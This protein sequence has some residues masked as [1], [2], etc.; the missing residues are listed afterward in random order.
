[1]LLTAAAAGPPELVL[2]ALDFMPIEDGFGEAIVPLGRV[3][4]TRVSRRRDAGERLDALRNL[5]VNRLAR[6]REAAPP[7]V[8][9]VNGVQ[10][11]DPSLLT[12]LD[13]ILHEGP[14]V[15]VHGLIW[16]T[17]PSAVGERV[18]Q[19]CGVRVVG[20]L[21]TATSTA[22]IDSS[23]AAQ[24]RDHQVLLYDEFE[25]RLVLLRPYARAD[26]AWIATTTVS[27][28]SPRSHAE[29]TLT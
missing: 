28:A 19:R 11:A 1:V 24:L 17:T 16:G 12:H 21:D 4:T 9:A 23:R 15:G 2:D 20:P 3:I 22:L 25:S 7:V 29:I 26:A 18:L 8:F 13:Q 5:V 6:H 10:N 14:A 27:W